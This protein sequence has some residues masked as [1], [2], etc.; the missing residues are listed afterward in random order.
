MAEMKICVCD[1]D[2]ITRVKTYNTLKAKFA[3]VKDVLIVCS[4]PYDG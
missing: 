1:S 4:T 3:D 2:I